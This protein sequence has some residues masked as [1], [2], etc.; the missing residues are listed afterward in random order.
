MKAAGSPAAGRP[1]RVEGWWSRVLIALGLRA[2][3]NIAVEGPP[4]DRATLLAGRRTD[5]ATDR[6]FLAAER[7]L[8]AWIRTSL[9]MISF[10]FSIAKVFEVLAKE[11]GPLKGLFG[12]T[13][14]PETLGV[15]LIVIGTLALVVAVVQHR[16]ALVALRA[17]GF[18]GPWSLAL[19]VGALVAVLGVLAFGGVVLRF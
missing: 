15:A 14:S 12:R 16:Q 13:H 8:M 9:S 11:R 2:A 17:E 5:L 6:T 7:T 19:T 4:P 3:P 1:P 18:Q 10:G